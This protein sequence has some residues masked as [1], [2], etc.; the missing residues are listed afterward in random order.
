MKLKTLLS[1]SYSHS[2]LL[3]NC[4]SSWYCLHS[5][6]T[7]T[8]NFRMSFFFNSNCILPEIRQ[9]FCGN[10]FP[11]KFGINFPCFS[12]LIWDNLYSFPF[13]DCFFTLCPLPKLLWLSWTSKRFQKN[14]DHHGFSID[15][16]SVFELPKIAQ[17]ALKFLGFF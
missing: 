8:T 11:Q 12:S 13:N 3:H 1:T 7:A 6:C 9:V 10:T 4:A 14:V 5:P 15:K 16:N 17:M 2:S